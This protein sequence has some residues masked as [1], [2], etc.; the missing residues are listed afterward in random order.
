[1]LHASFQ[2]IAFGMMKHRYP[3]DIPCWREI[4]VLLLFSSTSHALMRSCYYGSISIEVHFGSL[5]AKI[6][7][8]VERRGGFY[9]KPMKV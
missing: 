3:G 6:R 4:E 9:H 5:G 2:M 8:F 7:I 1:M